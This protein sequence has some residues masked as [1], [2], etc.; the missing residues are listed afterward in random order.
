MADGKDDF[1]TKS[2]ESLLDKAHRFYEK[3]NFVLAGA[4]F[5]AALNLLD[6][7]RSDDNRKMA[8]NIEIDIGHSLFGHGQ[9]DAAM[10]HYDAALG[11]AMGVNRDSSVV[12]A[13]IHAHKASVFFETGNYLRAARNYFK[14]YCIMKDDVLFDNHQLECFDFLVQAKESLIHV[15]ITEKNEKKVEELT[16]S[17]ICCQN[18]LVTSLCAQPY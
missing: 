17:V 1:P 2:V 11:R 14:A 13:E 12:A 9:F 10:R 16:R 15:E 6:S 4:S 3:E 8:I 7:E 18:E 5:A